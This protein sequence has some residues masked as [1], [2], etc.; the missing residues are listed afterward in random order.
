MP[1]YSVLWS[2]P[3]CYNDVLTACMITLKKGLGH[4]IKLKPSVCKCYANLNFS[5]FNVNGSK[6]HQNGNCDFIWMSGIMCKFLFSFY[7]SLLPL[8]KKRTCKNK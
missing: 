8:F 1:S 7:L 3:D 2:S 6:I 5:S 4:N